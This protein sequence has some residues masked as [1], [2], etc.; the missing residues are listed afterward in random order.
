MFVVFWP[1]RAVFDF[2]LFCPR[3]LQDLGQLLA[4]MPFDSP[5]LDRNVEH[6]LTSKCPRPFL[7]F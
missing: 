6:L 5:M 1:I 7:N 4:W 2:T 3:L